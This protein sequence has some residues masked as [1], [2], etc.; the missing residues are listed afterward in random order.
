MAIWAWD[1]PVGR[2]TMP[3]SGGTVNST[4]FPVPKGVKTMQ[5]HVPALVGTGATIK[6]QAL[7]PVVLVETAA[8]EVWTDVVTMN[9]SDGSMVAL[10]G[11]VES[12][13]VTIPVSATGGGNLRFVASEDQSS[14]PSTIH[15]AY[16]RD[17]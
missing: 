1:G 12:T 7:S 17:G 6:L 5:V 9:L 15:I 4:P 3:V 10:D 8:S 16:N 11:L 13:C 14:V 2:I